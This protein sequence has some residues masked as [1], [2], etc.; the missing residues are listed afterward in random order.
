MPEDKDKFLRLVEDSYLAAEEK[1][2]LKLLAE[3][4][5]TPELWRKLDDLLVA[6]LEERRGAYREFR[7][8]LDAEIARYTADYERE[9]KVL[10][11][12]MRED[13]SRL[14]EGDDA[15]RD[16][17]WDDYYAAVHALQGR[18]LDE[19]RKTSKTVLQTTVLAA[20]F[21]GPVAI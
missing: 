16:R 10:D 4:G 15:E 14:G 8:R 3:G 6:G 21:R 17:L 9:K 20:V 12:R 19:M 7:G 13:L 1:D 5:V 2:G 18:L 11:G